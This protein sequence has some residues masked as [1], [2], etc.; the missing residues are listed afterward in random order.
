MPP[1]ESVDSELPLACRLSTP[2]L[3]ARSAQLREEVFAA[4]D[5][6]REIEDGYAFRF[7]RTADW[8]LRLADF[9]VTERECCPFFRFNL[10]VE[11]DSGPV[12]L[13][14]TGPAG[15]KRFI[16]ETFLPEPGA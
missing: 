14:L 5:M 1:K 15:T 11:A 4:V 13:T 8:I 10:A 6:Q 2:E 9:V 7:S 3:G 12:W 16:T